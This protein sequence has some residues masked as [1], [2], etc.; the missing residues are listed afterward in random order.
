MSARDP[1]PATANQMSRTWPRPAVPA[2]PQPGTASPISRTWPQPDVRARSPWTSQVSAFSCRVWPPCVPATEARYRGSP[3]RLATEAACYHQAR[4]RGSP[5]RLAAE[6]RHR[7]C[8]LPRLATASRLHRGPSSSAKCP[9]VQLHSRT[10][11]SSSPKCNAP[12]RDPQPH[13]RVRP[14]RLEVDPHPNVR[15]GYRPKQGDPASDQLAPEPT[16]KC[17]RRLAKCHGR[18]PPP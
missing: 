2:R 17:P 7:V 18:R 3:P 14:A 4:H 16:A 12:T 9:R 5:P 15:V 6:A 1:R 11:L 10:S 13:V 8:L